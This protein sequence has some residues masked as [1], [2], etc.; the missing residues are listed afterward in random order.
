MP[1]ISYIGPW[2]E[3]QTQKEEQ[4]AVVKKGREAHMARSKSAGVETDE[5]MGDVDHESK[6]NKETA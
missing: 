4:R 5:K 1:I 3:D 2:T 6:H